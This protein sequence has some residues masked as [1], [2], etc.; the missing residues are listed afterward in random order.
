[1]S[2]I[3]ILIWVFGLLRLANYILSKEPA[4][5]EK[6]YSIQQPTANLDRY[7]IL[8]CY[9]IL[10]LDPTKNFSLE[11][12]NKAYYRRLQE[13]SEQRDKGIAPQYELKEYQSAKKMMTDYYNYAA[14]RN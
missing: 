10:N 4:K 12:V 3:W 13:M 6:T 2:L 8:K 14:Y 11:E 9:Y 5:E 1:M 7:P